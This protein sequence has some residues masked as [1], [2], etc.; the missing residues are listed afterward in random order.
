MSQKN[1]PAHKAGILE[2]DI[3]IDFNGRKI[4]DVGMLRNLVAQSKIV[5]GILCH[6][7]P[8]G[9]RISHQV[10]TIELPNDVPEIPT[11]PSPN[12][13]PLQ[14]PFRVRRNRSFSGSR[15]TARTGQGRKRVVIL[16]IE[17]GASADDAVSARRQ[18]CRKS[19]VSGSPI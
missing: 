13:K 7:Y 19:S 16:K 6:L 1:S 15:K 12:R 9:K 18:S 5:S 8:A 3:I 17:P 14:M 4:T 10:T 11:R 2:G